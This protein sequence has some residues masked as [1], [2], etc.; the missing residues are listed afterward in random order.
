MISIYTT[1]QARTQKVI[2]SSFLIQQTSCH[3]PPSAGHKRGEDEI[4]VA[5][6]ETAGLVSEHMFFGIKQ[7]PRGNRKQKLYLQ[8]KNTRTMN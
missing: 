8:K 3:L 6:P 1:M 7:I 2:S 4:T 5:E